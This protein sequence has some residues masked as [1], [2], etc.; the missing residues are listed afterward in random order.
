MVVSL[1]AFG[2]AAATALVGLLI[3]LH[4]VSSLKDFY[5]AAYCS[6][7]EPT[8]SNLLSQYSY[9]WSWRRYVLFRQFSRDPLRPPALRGPFELAF[10]CLW[11]RFAALA[12]FIWSIFGPS[13]S[14]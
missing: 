12:V 7:G 9:N 8:Y 1:T 4:L 5:P 10:W 14:A 11:L 3:E 6:A 13:A 2:V